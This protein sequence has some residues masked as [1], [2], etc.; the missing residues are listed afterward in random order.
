MM[1]TATDGMLAR[2]QT[3][4]CLIQEIVRFD[5][6]RSFRTEYGMS[7]PCNHVY[8][9]NSSRSRVPSAQQLPT[10]STTYSIA[11]TCCHCRE[12]L[13][14]LVNF[15][16]NT[17]PCPSQSQ[18]FHLFHHVVAEGGREVAAHGALRYQCSS[19]P[20]QAELLLFFRGPVLTGE[21]VAYLTSP[22]ALYE[23]Y[24]SAQAMFPETR[25]K[26]A[27]EILKVLR[28]AVI[29][30]LDKE[31]KDMRDIPVDNKVFKACLGDGIESLFSRLGFSKIVSSPKNKVHWRLPRPLQHPF[32][33]M[34]DEQR[35]R[36]ED[37]RDELAAMMLH[38]PESERKLV[39]FPIPE[40][41]PAQPELEKILGIQSGELHQS[42]FSFLQRVHFSSKGKA[43]FKTI[44]DT[45][46]NRGTATHG[47][48]IPLGYFKHAFWPGK[49][50]ADVKTDDAKTLNLASLGPKA[51]LSYVTAI[52]MEYN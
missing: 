50:R 1:D 34:Y 51:E 41:Q 5:L 9:T 40:L 19:K 38:R 13:D 20:C 15:P 18:P 36:L 44:S 42:F 14:A 37:V 23:R 25:Q 32:N 24:I 45:S 46:Q 30:S 43:A 10:A 29:D 11:A 33:P 27:L 47:F 3:A 48:S 21:D 39:S 35:S 17:Q 22:P 26:P 4:P 31:E 12:H 52:T 2:N 28:N 16:A 6:D 8:F 7:K 49:T